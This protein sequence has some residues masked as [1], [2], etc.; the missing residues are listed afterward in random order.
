M[1]SRIY[2]STTKI[3]PSSQP[4]LVF[5][6][7]IN[8]FLPISYRSNRIVKDSTK[9]EHLVLGRRRGRRVEREAELKERQKS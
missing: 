4:E 1:S 3:L 7:I 8:K 9:D 5:N 6:Q 2:F